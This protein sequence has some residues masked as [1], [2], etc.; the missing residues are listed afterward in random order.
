[1]SYDQKYVV[2]ITVGNLDEDKGFC[3]RILRCYIR[4]EVFIFIPGQLNVAL[5]IWCLLTIR[6]ES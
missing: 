4:R 6:R 1:M 3:E 5:L 2:N